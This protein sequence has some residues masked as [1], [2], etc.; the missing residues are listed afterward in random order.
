MPNDS[1]TGGY[2][3]PTSVNGSLNDSALQVFIQNVVVGV[4]GMPGNLVR[5]RWQPESVN[6]P[7]AG[8]NWAAIGASRRTRDAFAFEG[9][10]VGPDSDFI[11][12]HEI[13]DILASFY[14]PS[15]EANAELMAIGLQLGQNREAMLLAGYGL[16]SVSET[17]IAPEL[18]HENYWLYRADVAFVVRRVVKY[19]Y[20]VLSLAGSSSTLQTQAAAEVPQTTNIIN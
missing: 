12:F 18:I 10:T 13:L 16:I 1:S 17:N 11:Q 4:T 3:V 19:T 20:A 8:T 15:A 9:H 14:G 6:I 5:P 2:L 7:P